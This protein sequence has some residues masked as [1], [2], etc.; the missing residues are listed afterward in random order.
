MDEDALKAISVFMRGTV[1]RVSVG[2]AQLAPECNVVFYQERRARPK[3]TRATTHSR[4]I[5]WG[6]SSICYP[7]ARVSRTLV[8]WEL[9]A[10]GRVCLEGQPTTPDGLVVHPPKGEEKE[11]KESRDSSCAR[12][13]P[14]RREHLLETPFGRHSRARPGTNPPEATFLSTSKKCCVPPEGNVC[15][16]G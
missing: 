15:S 5:P 7:R 8:R 13:S 9:S 1:G 2:R 3:D 14:S 4:Y 10:V 6:C 16:V 11:G 12:D